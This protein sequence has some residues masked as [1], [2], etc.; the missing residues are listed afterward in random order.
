MTAPHPLVVDLLARAVRPHTAGLDDRA[1]ATRIVELGGCWGGRWSWAVR[2]TRTI[3]LHQHCLLRVAPGAPPD[4]G[5]PTRPWDAPIAAVLAAARD[6]PTG[7][8]CDMH[9]PWC[10]DDARIFGACCD[11]CPDTPE[12]DEETDRAH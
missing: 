1:A 6:L 7:L 12:D 2:G 4:P 11:G 9:G 10:P 3:R 5:R 8:C